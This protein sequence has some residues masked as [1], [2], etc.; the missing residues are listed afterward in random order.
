MRDSLMSA[1]CRGKVSE[2]EAATPPPETASL[3]LLLYHQSSKSTRKRLTS[4]K[5]TDKSTTNKACTSETTSTEFHSATWAWRRRSVKRH[6]SI[7]QN[8]EFQHKQDSVPMKQDSDRS[9]RCLP[10]IN[11]CCCHPFDWFQHSNFYFFTE[12]RRKIRWLEMQRTK[13][14]N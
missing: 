6:Y 7:L 1:S 11:D 9:F 14:R 10:F 3:Q 2:W 8:S 4:K 5:A 12:T 13:R